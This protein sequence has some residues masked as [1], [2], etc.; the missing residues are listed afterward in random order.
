MLIFLHT[1]MNI[2]NQPLGYDKTGDYLNGLIVRI[3]DKG[4]YIHTYIYI[5]IYIY[6]CMYLYVCI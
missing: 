3:K 5:Y 6:I 1:Y 4:E 2:H